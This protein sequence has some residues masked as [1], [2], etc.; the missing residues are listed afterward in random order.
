MK[1]LRIIL[2][3]MGCLLLLILAAC[4]VQTSTPEAP[5]VTATPQPYPAAMSAT[6]PTAYPAPATDTPAPAPTATSTTLP[7][8][9]ETPR[10]TQADTPTPAPTP[11]V[12][13]I[14]FEGFSCAGRTSCDVG[15]NDKASSFS[16][17][18]DGTN[19]KSIQTKEVPPT[20]S[21]PAS[22][23]LEHI[24]DIVSVPHK[25]GDGH[26]LTYGTG[27]RDPGLYLVNLDNG[28]ITRLFQ[29]SKESGVLYWIGPACWAPDGKTI[30]FLLESRQGRGPNSYAV[31]VLDL[32]NEKT[33]K[34]YQL[35]IT[36]VT[37]NTIC[38]PDG[39]EMI[40]IDAGSKVEENGLIVVEL[41]SGTTRQIL[42]EYSVWAIQAAAAQ[43]P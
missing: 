43:Q 19:L 39:Q 6:A 25:S 27:A 42:S 23:P 38:S 32:S 17:R 30:R 21:L 33:T 36:A 40:L 12:W 26:R 34:V 1:P 2:L 41:G 13:E 4:A 16:I 31:Y 29:P 11:Q 5:A 3:F 18:S 14:W 15:P 7:S 10:P 9:T 37:I 35:Q 8:P 28:Q 22:V 24:K 20:P